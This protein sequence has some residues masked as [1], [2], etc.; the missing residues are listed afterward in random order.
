MIS[1]VN[2]GQAIKHTDYWQSEQARVGYLFLSWNAGA[3]RL[4]VP[5]ASE[6]LLKE[7]RGSQYVIISKGEPE[8]R[9]ALEL[10]FEDG[11]DTPFVVHILLEQSDRLQTEAEQGGDFVVRVWTRGGSQLQY[12][13]KYRVV[14]T[15]PD[16][17][18]WQ[19]H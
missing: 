19:A 3:A 6:A 11:S 17:S 13:G 16:F 18:P 15:L 4:L 1:V 9:A 7:V 8:G 5:D 12:P 10:L 14:G 2:E